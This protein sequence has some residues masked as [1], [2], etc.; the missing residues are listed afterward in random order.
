MTLS[1]YAARANLSYLLHQHPDWTHTQ[2]AAVLGYSKAWVKKWRAR[3]REELA[4]GL[5]LEQIWQGHSRARKHLPPQTHPLVVEQILAIRDQPPEGLRRVP[6]QEAIH[7]SLERDPALQFFQLP[8]PSCKTIYRVLK[9]HQRI[10][11]RGQPVHQPMAR[12]KPMTAWQIDFKA[13]SSVPADQEGKRQHVVEPL[14]IID[15]GTSVSLDAQVRADFTAETALEALASTLAKYG[16]PTCITLDRDPR[17]V[18]SPAGSDFPAALVRFGACLGIEIV[19]CDPHQPQ[20]NGFV[21]RY[22]RTSQA[23]CL[24][25]DRPADLE[26]AQAAT[27]AFVRHYKVE[28]PHQ[29]LACG[30]RPPLTAFPHLAALPPLPATV[31]PDG[32]L[33]QFDGVHLER[34]VDR[35]GMIS[36]DL[37][38]YYVSARLVG[39]HVVLHLDAKLRCVQVLHAQQVIKSLP[40]RGLVGQRLSFAQFLTHMLR[41]ARAQARLCSLQQRKYRTSA[42]ASP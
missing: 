5:P 33:S 25:L 22:H 9:T 12:P 11:E 18:G 14:N 35:H 27:A 40:L 7:Y 34:K 2:F 39:H 6:G 37:K 38:R 32:W 24:A 16:C 36:L 4:A 8:V 30:H 13:V 31:N 29:G 23:E 28:R 19:I 17:W 26:H 42:V 15:T 3:L 1:Y 21:E 41:Q 10:P 20:Q